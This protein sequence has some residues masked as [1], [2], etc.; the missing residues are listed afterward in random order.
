M[1]IAKI[2][3]FAI[4]I[5]LGATLALDAPAFACEPRSETDPRC[6]MAVPKPRVVA[7]P[8]PTPTAVRVAVV[9]TPVPA[10]NPNSGGSPQDALP[11]N[12]TWQIVNAN[13][14][15]WYRIDNG[16]N[17]YLTV[18]VDTKDKKTIRMSA[19]APDQAG[20]LSLSTQPK[21]WADPWKESTAH[22]YVQNIKHGEGVWH[23]VV[24]NNNPFPVEHRL[25]TTGAGDDRTCKSFWEVDVYGRNVYWTDCGMYGLNK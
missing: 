6:Q 12:N 8:A 21:G 17:F 3:M 1:K 14:V 16:K 25:S 18:Y 24:H 2:C 4:L 9:S 13:Q 5:A 22:D 10:I 23:F 15:K 11:I 7:R 19:Y 20:E